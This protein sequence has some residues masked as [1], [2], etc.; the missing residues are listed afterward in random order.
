MRVVISASSLLN[1]IGGDADLSRRCL[2]YDMHGL[3]F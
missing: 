1:I 2:P 3:S